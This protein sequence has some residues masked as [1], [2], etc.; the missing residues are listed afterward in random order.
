ML[1]FRP[2]DL[3]FQVTYI[4]PCY[5]IIFLSLAA[6]TG[7]SVL[8]L[9][10]PTELERNAFFYYETPFVS[11]QQVACVWPRSGSYGRIQRAIFY[12]LLICTIGITVVIPKEKGMW[13]A[14][15]A[16]ISAMAYS[17]AAAV[18][19]IVIYGE[20]PHS[21]KPW[22]P[23]LCY[24]IDLLPGG[25]VRLPVCFGVEDLDR[26]SVCTIVGTAM[27]AALPMAAWSKLM[28]EGSR[29]REAAK[30]ILVAWMLLM[31]VSHVFCAII[32]TDQAVHYQICPRGVNETLPLNYYRNPSYNS[33]VFRAS[34][35]ALVTNST[36][37]V[38]QL[39]QWISP[40]SECMYSCTT[41]PDYLLRDTRDISVW[42]IYL[43]SLFH[44]PSTSMRKLGIAF[45]AIYLSFSI[46]AL[47]TPTK[48]PGHSQHDD[49]A[50][51]D[52]SAA[53]STKTSTSRRTS[54]TF[55]CGTATDGPACGSCSRSSATCRGS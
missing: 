29:V 26:T 30:P 36:Q 42:S 15:G 12:I 45:W 3:H 10:N 39:D 37:F 53:G 41:M 1:S 16:A 40:P 21:G 38:S 34:I 20:S 47:W 32:R 4:A 49:S 23:P 46:V 31:A 51:A 25:E 52:A 44:L 17:G 8:Y 35:T 27:L 18:H 5:A 13:L 24:Y 55:T 54:A 2:R 33:A 50:S 9:Y 14:T 11:I 22:N 19:Q 43:P 48:P 6:F 28:R 7:F